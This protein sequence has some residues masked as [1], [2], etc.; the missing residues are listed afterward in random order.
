LS[1]RT[2][3]TDSPC[4]H[5]MAVDYGS[6]FVRVLLVNLNRPS[7]SVFSLFKVSDIVQRLC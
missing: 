3:G 2:E 5:Y 6:P 1:T 7:Y 4:L